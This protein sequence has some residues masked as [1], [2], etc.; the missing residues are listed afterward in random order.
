MT[1][2]KGKL[3]KE[4]P[5]AID[6]TISTTVAGAAADG[7]EPENGNNT[8]DSDNDSNN[9][10][11]VAKVD[12]DSDKYKVALKVLNKI[13]TNDGKPEI[14][15]VTK[16]VN[17]DREKIVTDV[18]RISIE[19]MENEIFE[20][21]NKKGCGY[22]RKTKYLVLNFV[23]GMIKELGYKMARSRK[24]KSEYINGLSYKRTH[25]LYSVK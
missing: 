25:S 8:D 2:R 1:G 3:V 23:R 7:L 10:N 14:D 6:A 15:D 21:F 20:H 5:H 19:E 13:L 18:N 24:E 16:F 22:F 12:K 4:K 9:D 17:I 11:N